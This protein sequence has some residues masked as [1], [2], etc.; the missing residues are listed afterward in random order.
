[1]RENKSNSSPIPNASNAT[2]PVNNLATVSLI[3]TFFAAPIGLVLGFIALAQI[4]KSNE[5]GRPLAIIAIV[6][7]SIFTFFLFILFVGL[8]MASNAVNN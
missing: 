3:M 1:M 7:S 6:I 8:A 5:G 2:V 4:N